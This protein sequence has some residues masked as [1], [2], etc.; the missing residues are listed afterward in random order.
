MNNMDWWPARTGHPGALTHGNGSSI[1]YEGPNSHKP[2]L[3]SHP[4]T[5]VRK[6]DKDYNRRMTV[7]QTW[8]V[9]GIL[10]ATLMATFGMFFYLG[11]KIDTLGARL[12]A[13]IDGLTGRIDGLTGRIDSLSARMDG[14]SAQ[15]ASHLSERHP[16]C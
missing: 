5:M 2:A 14:L 8:A 7:E 3:V 16:S 13:R 4:L 15:M 11:N 12:D 1:L 6:T 10:A 9:I